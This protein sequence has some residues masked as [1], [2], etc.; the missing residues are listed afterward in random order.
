M[1]MIVYIY[2]CIYMYI[3]MYVYMYVFL[4]WFFPLVADHGGGGPLGAL[5]CVFSS[6]FFVFL[7]FGRDTHICVLKTHI[8]IIYNTHTH[9]THIHKQTTTN[10]S[11][12]RR[13]PPGCGLLPAL[14]GTGF[15]VGCGAGLCGAD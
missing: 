8:H 13:P 12:R 5:G 14:G 7:L 6:F 15:G 9:E 10:N 2:I 11:R 1:Y 4:V 3:C